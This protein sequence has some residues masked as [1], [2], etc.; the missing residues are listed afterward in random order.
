MTTASATSSPLATAPRRDAGPVP[1]PAALRDQIQVNEDLPFVTLVTPAVGVSTM[2][3]LTELFKAHRAWFMDKVTRRGVLLCRGFP[4]AD[5][6]DFH[7][8]VNEGMALTPWNGFNL[9]GLPGFVGNWLRKYAEGLMGSGDYRRYL[10][11]DAV[12]LGPAG[13]SIQGPHVEGGG[14]PKRTRF[15]TLCCFEPSEHLA[16]TAVVD[17]H[18]AYQRLPKALQDK[19][20][21]AYNRFYFI[22][23][24]KLSLL[25][26][27]ILSQSPMKI[28][29]TL[30]DGRAKL[31]T[32]PTHAVSTHPE[33]G[34]LCLQPW[35]FARNTN[36]HVHAAAK[37]C[38]G[39][40]R[41]HIDRC[42]NADGT[43]YIWDLCDEQG[44]DVSWTDAEQR[45]FF[46]DMFKHAY[47]VKWQKGDVAVVDNVRMGHWRMNGKQGNRKLVQIQVE[48]FDADLH[49]PVA[50]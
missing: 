50:A 36:T 6:Q 12:Q 29:D 40:T 11:R 16:E 25:D 4:P 22:T 19:Y 34:D 43:N 20:F 18:A 3:K 15:L 7:Q 1:M 38:Y 32:K 48:S 30:P 45:E 41:G 21:K 8:L 2:P 14:S 35:A 31:A 27:L 9:K 49:P 28:Y 17:L 44:R 10:D 24:R 39:D 37:A 13:D 47:L 26:R 33:T 23:A 42:P 46:D 5:T